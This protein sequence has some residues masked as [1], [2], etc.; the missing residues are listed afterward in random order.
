MPGSALFGDD[1][2]GSQADLTM[3]GGKR[4]WLGYAEMVEGERRGVN[5]G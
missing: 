1:A 2:D 4:S 5:A 3:L